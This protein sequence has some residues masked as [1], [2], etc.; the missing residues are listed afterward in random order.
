MNENDSLILL[1]LY[2][3]HPALSNLPGVHRQAIE[4]TMNEVSQ[5]CLLPLASSWSKCP[6]HTTAIPHFL[7]CSK[8]QP[9]STELSGLADVTQTIGLLFPKSVRLP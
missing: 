5:P 9:L 4:A 8:L 7:A 3:R 2:P 6:Q 1:L